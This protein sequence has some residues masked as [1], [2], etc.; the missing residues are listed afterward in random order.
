MTRIQMHLRVSSRKHNMSRGK[1]LERGNRGLYNI[2]LAAYVVVFGENTK[3][4]LM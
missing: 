1:Q 3:M 2:S 4:N